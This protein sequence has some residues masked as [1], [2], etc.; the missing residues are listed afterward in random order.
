VLPYLYLSDS[1][2]AEIRALEDAGVT[3]S[4]RDL[5]N[6]RRVESKQLTPAERRA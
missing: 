6:G 2:S 3:V 1:E 4:A 5:P